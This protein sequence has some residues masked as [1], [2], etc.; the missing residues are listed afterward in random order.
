MGKKTGKVLKRVR[1]A[2]GL[3]D[4]E[5]IKLTPTATPKLDTSFEKL[6]IGL[7]LRDIT[8]LYNPEL[9]RDKIESIFGSKNDN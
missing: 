5:D 7:K 8:V 3:M 9:S 1:S 2:A 4:T 6:Q